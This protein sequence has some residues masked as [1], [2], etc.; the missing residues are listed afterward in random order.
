MASRKNYKNFKFLVSIL[1]CAMIIAATV[2]DYTSVAWASDS[3]VQ[4]TIDNNISAELISKEDKG[5]L[6]GLSVQTEMTETLQEN[7][8][9]KESTSQLPQTE[10][11]ISEASENKVK[12]TVT[13]ITGNQQNQDFSSVSEALKKIDEYFA[14]NNI[15]SDDV[16][17]KYTIKFMADRYVLTEDDVQAIETARVNTTVI[18]D[19]LYKEENDDSYYT[20]LDLNILGDEGIFFANNTVIQNINL[21]YDKSDINDTDSASVKGDTANKKYLVIAANGYKL[22]MGQNVET[23]ANT[24]IYSGFVGLEEKEISLGTQSELIINS[25]TYESVIAGGSKEQKNSKIIIQDGTINNIYGSESA[26]LDTTNI[27]VRGG[28]HCR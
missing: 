17:A 8:T 6:E 9:V 1:L 25:G 3:T 10:T 4:Q 28:V 16:N 24:K 20:N 12:N 18:Y 14:W 2:I 19:G 7:T 26:N 21:V 5:D 22:T 13:L 27:L 11:A 15:S 23:P